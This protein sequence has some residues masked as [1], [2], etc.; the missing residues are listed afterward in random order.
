VTAV[1]PTPVHPPRLPPVLTPLADPELVDGAEW[2]GVEIT[3]EPGGARDV[4]Y[5]E[6]SAS[7]LAN[8][9]LT[10]RR[11]D[12][13]RLVDVLVEDCELSGVTLTDSHFTRVELRRCRLSGLVASTLRAR[14]VRFSECR[15][16]G[17]MF[18]MTTW[19]HAELDDVDLRDADFYAAALTGVRMTGC[20]LTG[21]D[22]SKATM[23]GTRLHG[24]TLEG[25]RGADSLR[26]A[27]IGPDQVLPVAFSVLA[28]LGIV[29]EDE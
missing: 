3:G 13:L 2:T 1:K 7:R 5:L 29:V 9:R 24:S 14:H 28:T 17:A 15:A 11:F 12:H 19:D 23:A 4:A 8:V 6:L 25:I 18:R 10:G 16:D 26:G 27:V 21:A 20:D 22:L